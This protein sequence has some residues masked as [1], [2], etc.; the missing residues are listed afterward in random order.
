V[1]CIKI[2]QFL[3]LSVFDDSD[4][5][6]CFNICH[7][8]FVVLWELLLYF[9]I[10]LLVWFFETC[11]QGSFFERQLMNQL[12]DWLKKT[13][14]TIMCDVLDCVFECI[15]EKCSSCFLIVVVV[16][17]YPMRSQVNRIVCHPTLPVTMTAHEDRHIRFFD[18]NSGKNCCVL[19][20]LFVSIIELLERRSCTKSIWEV[21]FLLQLICWWICA[22][23]ENACLCWHYLCTSKKFPKNFAE[24]SGQIRISRIFLSTLKW[25]VWW[26]LAE[27]CSHA[28]LVVVSRW[29][30]YSLL[31]C[32]LLRWTACSAVHF[33]CNAVTLCMWS[34]VWDELRAV[35]CISVVMLSHSVVVN[36]VTG[37]SWTVYI[38]RQSYSLH[39]STSRCSHKSCYWP[40]WTLSAVRKWVLSDNM[41]HLKRKFFSLFFT[42]HMLRS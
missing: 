38:C 18:N 33:C 30:W 25:M 26:V 31:L 42:P 16:S 15:C 37:V 6:C 4:C 22:T 5:Y 20:A 27:L 19:L 40:K 36:V 23:Q 12:F 14:V 29:F 1:S 35:L 17:E 24:I 41:L 9:N 8:G 7:W 13:V 39:G 10:G 3:S 21:M 32:H 28:L 2:V 34:L 11:G